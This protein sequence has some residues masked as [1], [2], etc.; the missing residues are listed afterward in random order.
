MTVT[1]DLDPALALQ[2]DL[3]SGALF[4]AFDVQSAMSRRLRSFGG[5]RKRWAA[6]F[7]VALASGAACLVALALVQQALGRKLPPGGEAGR[8]ADE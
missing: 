3:S 7:V 1:L 5:D 4:T 6:P 2:K 8:L